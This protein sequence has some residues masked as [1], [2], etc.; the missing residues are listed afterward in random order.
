VE[1]DIWSDPEAAAFVREHADGNETVPTV[2]IAG[3]V[4]VNPPAG[5]VVEL[6]A[7]VGIAGTPAGASRFRRRH[8]D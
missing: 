4:L 5:R 1:V 3:T 8:R 7:A 2:D 6:A